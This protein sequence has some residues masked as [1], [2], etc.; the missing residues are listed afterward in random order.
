M[1]LG[2]SRNYVE[3][4]IDDTFTADDAW[5]IATHSNDYTDA[6]SLRMSA[7]DVVNAAQWSQVNDFRMDQLF[8]GGGSVAYQNGESYLAPPGPDP[9]LAQFQATDPTTGEPYADDFG[10]ISHTYDTPY[11][12]V[13]CATENYIE[14]ELN[15]NTN[16]AAA[17]AGA[18]AGTGGLGLTESTNTSDALGTENPQVFVP[19][20]TPPIWTPRT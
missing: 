15:E 11:L 2:L 3:M 8:N 5:S 14:A 1:H 19:P 13:G 9:V 17:P 20:S 6:D 16:W 7:A 18:S 12:D 4:D 10:W